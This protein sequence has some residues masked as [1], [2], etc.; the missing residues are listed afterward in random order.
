MQTQGDYVSFST[1]INGAHV[2]VYVSGSA[3]AVRPWCDLRGP[4]LERHAVSEAIAATR[5][6]DLEAG[7][8]VTVTFFAD[9]TI[10]VTRGIE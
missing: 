8:R 9:G 10:K 5:G 4:A 7:D 3:M 2:T 6:L 1:S